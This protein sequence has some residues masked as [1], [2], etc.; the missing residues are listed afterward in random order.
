MQCFLDGEQPTLNFHSDREVTEWLTT[1]YMSAEKERTLEWKPLGAGEHES[2]CSPRLS[3]SRLLAST[4]P[5][6]LDL[7]RMAPEELAWGES[8]L[9]SFV[10]T[11]TSSLFP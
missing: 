6:S 5:C 4:P 9:H 2:L 3:M 8:F 1:A 7:L 10:T 11:P